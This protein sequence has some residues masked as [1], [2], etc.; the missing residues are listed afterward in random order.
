MVLPCQSRRT[1]LQTQPVLDDLAFEEAWVLV[2]CFVEGR[3]VDVVGDVAY[4]EAVPLCVVCQRYGHTSQTELTQSKYAFIAFKD[5]EEF[6]KAWK[7]MD[8]ELIRPSS[9]SR[10]PSPAPCAGKCQGHR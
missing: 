1:H 10:C 8:G 7:E 6:L 3:F 4:E 5:P 9:D 2:E